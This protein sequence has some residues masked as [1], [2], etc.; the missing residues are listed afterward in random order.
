MPVKQLYQRKGLCAII[1]AV[2][3]VQEVFHNTKQV[4]CDGADTATRGAVPAY[5]LG[6]VDTPAVVLPADQVQ[7]SCMQSNGTDLTDNAC[8]RRR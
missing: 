3:E 6:T 4:C 8:M 2:P 7:L 1:S 5:Q